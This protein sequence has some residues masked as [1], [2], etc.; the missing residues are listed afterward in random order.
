VGAIFGMSGVFSG[1]GERERELGARNRR[2]PIYLE[3]V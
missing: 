2:S 3:E 1:K